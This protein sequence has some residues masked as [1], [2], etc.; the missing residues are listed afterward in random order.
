MT[1]TPESYKICIY[2]TDQTHIFNI[3]KH[4]SRAYITILVIA[5]KIDLS[6]TSYSPRKTMREIGRA[7]II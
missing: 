3:K 1:T 6:L 4:M 2:K 5:Q 7:T